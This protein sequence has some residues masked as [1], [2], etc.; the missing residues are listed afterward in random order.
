M[1]LGLGNRG[2]FGSDHRALPSLILRFDC[3]DSPPAGID[4]R[5]HLSR[6]LLETTGLGRVK[7]LLYL[8]Q[9]VSATAF[10]PAG[11]YLCSSELLRPVPYARLESAFIRS[12]AVAILVSMESLHRALSVFVLHFCVQYYLGSGRLIAIAISTKRQ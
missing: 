11:F 8:S 2:T 12:A 5:M 3:S 1:L 4:C 10:C 7:C 9:V 6:W